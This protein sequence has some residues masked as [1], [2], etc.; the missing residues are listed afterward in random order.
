MART[1]DALQRLVDAPEDEP[2]LPAHLYR[3]V[4]RH[5]VAQLHGEDLPRLRMARLR[6][7][8]A[9]NRPDGQPAD[10]RA[11]RDARL[12]R[13]GHRVT[14]DRVV[15]RREGVAVERHL[16]PEV[17]DERIEVALRRQ[18]AVD[19]HLRPLA[20]VQTA[21][22]R[23][24]T[25]RARQHLPVPKETELAELR[26]AA[27]VVRRPALRGARLRDVPLQVAR[28]DDR[29]AA[30]DEERRP[31]ADLQPRVPQPSPREV[32]AARP[33]LHKRP[34]LEQAPRLDLHHLAR[35]HVKRRF[36]RRRKRGEEAA[37]CHQHV[38]HRRSPSF[39]RSA[40]PASRRSSSPPR[41]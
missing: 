4:Q 14:P 36:V 1:G 25:R 20:P 3:V 19:A 30:A 6:R 21:V 12:D 9:L 34:A 23:R 7:L 22:E 37:G 24:R 32:E 15:R 29:R 40:G 18:V 27:P 17:R 8:E 5:G 2:P 31:L 35:R 33:G 39:S 38:P 41:A 10:R 13:P 16:L 26:A 11:V 28:R